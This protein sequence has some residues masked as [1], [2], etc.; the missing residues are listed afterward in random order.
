MNY[1]VIQPDPTVWDS[2]V[3]QHPRGH[4]L[5][6]SAW[7]TLKSYYG[8]QPVR[9][10]ITDADQNI[11]AGGQILFRKLPF[12]LGTLAYLPYAPLVDWSNQ[13]QVQALMTALHQTA[14]R[15]RAVFLKIEPGYGIQP[16]WL[17]NSG[18]QLSPQTVQPPNTIILDLDDEESILARMNQGTRR[19]IRKSEKFEVQIRQGSREDVASFNAMLDETGRR[20]EFGVHVPSYYEHV[21]DLFVP[22][23]DAALLMG[24]YQGLDLAGVFVFKLGKQAWYLYGASRDAERQRMAAFGVQWAGVRWALEQ[25]CTSYD[26]VGIP[27]ENAAM[28]EAEFE[29]RSDG[30]WGVYRFKRGWGGRIARTVGAW[31]RV[32]NRPLYWLYQWYVRRGGQGD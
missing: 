29:N 22:A 25:G 4:L 24:S 2:F 15:H 11:C 9:V 18:F 1:S 17:Q 32:Y 19:N 27:D 12:R 28:L 23:G 10:A 3:R 20:Q 16:E 30:L 26:M 31:D 21:Y 7:G 5:Q 14:K 6:L 8:W 13:E